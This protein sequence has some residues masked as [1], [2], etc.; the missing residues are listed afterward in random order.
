MTARARRA[1]RA[2]WSG[3]ATPPP[4]LPAQPGA[5]AKVQRAGGGLIGKVMAPAVEIG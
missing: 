2:W 3:R 5:D 1:A 4:L